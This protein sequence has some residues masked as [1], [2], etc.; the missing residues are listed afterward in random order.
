[1]LGHRD[2]TVTRT[3]YV[4]EVAD[5]RRRVMRRSRLTAE[6]AGALRVALDHHSE[7]RRAGPAER[8]L[9]DAGLAVLKRN[10][11]QWLDLES[12]GH[13]RPVLRRAR[14]P[15]VKP[16][17]TRPRPSDH[18]Y[19]KAAVAAIPRS[20]TTSRTRTRGTA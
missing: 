3:V 1:M 19:G 8:R 7:D 16:D 9:H 11:G 2:G 13:R 6:F 17:V 15:V 10:K 14:M 5:A 20:S 4:H 18:R 12:I